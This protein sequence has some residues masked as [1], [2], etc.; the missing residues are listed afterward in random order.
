M[1]LWCSPRL[2]RLVDRLRIGLVL[3]SSLDGVFLILDVPRFVCS[4]QNF[5][6]AFHCSLIRAI[7]GEL[8]RGW[9]RGRNRR[10]GG[11]RL[12]GSGG[13]GLRLLRP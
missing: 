4:A 7:S 13:E 2:H 10:R 11:L 8:G 12:R 5:G 3:M 6:L 1:S 9:G